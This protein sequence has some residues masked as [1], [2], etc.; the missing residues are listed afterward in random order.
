MPQGARIRSARAV[1]D[2]LDLNLAAS[3]AV[4]S[5][6]GSAVGVVDVVIVGKR[7]LNID[8]EHQKLMGLNVS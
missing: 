4:D 2:N 1:W 7:L 3:M 5:R 8:G 6:P